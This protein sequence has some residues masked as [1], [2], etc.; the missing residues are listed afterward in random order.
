MTMAQNKKSRNCEAIR[1]RLYEYSKNRSLSSLGDDVT[2]HLQTCRDCREEFNMLTAL[3]R[4]EHAAHLGAIDPARLME[5][6][7]DVS[8]DLQQVVPT[9]QTIIGTLKNI[10]ADPRLS[11]EDK[12]RYTLESLHRFLFRIRSFL[13]S[14]Y[15]VQAGREWITLEKRRADLLRKILNQPEFRH[16]RRLVRL[17]ADA[18]VSRGLIFQLHGDTRNAVSNLSLSVVFHWALDSYDDLETRRFLGELKFYEGDWDAAEY[19]F[20]DA[21]KSPDIHPREQAVLLRNLGN[22]HYCRGNLSACHD[23]LEQAMTI[24]LSLDTPDYAARDLLNLSVI[25]YH[26]GLVP[27]AVNRLEQALKLMP[28]SAS[29]HLR[30]QLHANLGTCLAA[31]NCTD[32]AARH[33]RYALDCFLSGF[34]LADAAQVRRNKALMEY[35]TGNWTHAKSTLATAADEHREPD[36]LRCQILLLITRL[37]RLE[38]NYDTALSCSNDAIT[39][40]AGLNETL[41][42]DAIRLEQAF[43][44]LAEKRLDD[45]ADII[46]HTSAIKKARPCQAPSLFDLENESSLV[47]VFVAL[48]DHTA[49]ARCMRRL[50]RLIRK[51]KKSVPAT[52]NS[53]TNASGESWIHLTR[54]LAQH[55]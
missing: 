40:A 5:R 4:L 27:S 52:L 43:I 2:A 31:R 32:A 49:A 26:R 22:I 42:L 21:L 28:G 46:R 8:G 34:Y 18:Y 3:Q 17:Q 50:K 48:G 37:E 47:E 33:Y 16:L 39:L 35:Q 1:E 23:Y 44:A 20:S 30:G 45:L 14:R 54:R 19:L 15:P 10:H 36:A 29:D 7:A 38:G 13:Q 9:L 24:S 53:D 12:T 25:D 51:Y 6:L 55:I 41:L 11:A